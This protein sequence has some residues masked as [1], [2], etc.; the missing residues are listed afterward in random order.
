MLGSTLRTSYFTGIIG[1]ESP[2]I[3]M[4]FLMSEKI[5][6]QININK[7]LQIRTITNINPNRS[8][9]K[10]YFDKNI[11]YINKN[12]TSTMNNKDKIDSVF[13]AKQFIETLTQDERKIIMEQLTI[14]E[15]ENS[16]NLV[17]LPGIYSD[18]LI[19]LNKMNSKTYLNLD[20]SNITFRHLLVIS[21]Q[22]G[23]PFIGFGF[24]DNFIMI[25][26]VTLRFF[27]VRV[28]FCFLY[29]L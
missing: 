13:M 22:S 8:F 24:V 15:K 19:S 1:R 2:F 14:A 29:I 23:L 20:Q 18:L 25:V 6:N 5:L 9:L 17:K 21:L 3:S 10:K 16:L 11:L 4:S 27:L 12:V 26:A 7:S 28:S